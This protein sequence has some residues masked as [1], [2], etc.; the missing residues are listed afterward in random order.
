MAY[1]F[2]LL[3]N[4]VFDHFNWSSVSGWLVVAI[5]LTNQRG[6]ATMKK[7]NVLEFAGRDG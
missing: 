7:N 4:N 5:H 6:Y 2:E 3:L 1:A